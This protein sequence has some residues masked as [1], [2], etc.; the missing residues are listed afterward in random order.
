MSKKKQDELVKANNDS[1]KKV[2]L[3]ADFGTVY[4]RVKDNQIMR[5]IKAQMGLYEKLGHF[6]KVK[7]DYAIS[8]PGYK[9]LNK[10]ASINLV[11]PQR[12]MVDGKEQPNPY[13]ERNPKTKLIEHVNIRKIGIGYSPVGNITVID[14]TLYYNLYAYFIESIQAKMKKVVWKSGKPTDEKLHPN[15]AVIGTEKERPEKGSWAFFE[16]VSPLGI[17]INYEDPAIIDCLNEHT[18]KQRFGER[19][20]QTIVERNILKDHP[21]IGIGKVEPQKGDSGNLKAFV[22]VYGHRHEFGPPQI[23]EIL[24]QAEK[25]SETIEVKAEVID[26]VRLDE[27]KEALEEIKPEDKE[28]TPAEMNEPPEEFFL[29]QEEG[30][31]DREP[32]EDG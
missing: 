20:A 15:C 1:G 16:T 32:G 26:D 8:Y 28:K 22:T 23:N 11:T 3:T 29:H 10:V 17:W 19:I 12:V 14:K 31:A 27:E 13:V 21:A 18:Q 6:Y 25:G 24:A 7:N 9:H 30:K 2:A 5:P 4:I